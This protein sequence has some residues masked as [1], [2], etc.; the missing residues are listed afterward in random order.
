M[1]LLHLAR[2]LLSSL[3]WCPISDSTIQHRDK[4]KW[5]TESTQTCWN[6]AKSH[7]RLRIG[8]PAWCGL[9]S[10]MRTIQSVYGGNMCVWLLYREAFEH[11]CTA[12]G[13]HIHPRNAQTRWL[14]W[15]LEAWWDSW[16]G[17]DP[18][19]E[20]Y[21]CASVW[22]CVSSSKVSFEVYIY[23]SPCSVYFIWITVLSVPESL[24]CIHLCCSP[25]PFHQSSLLGP[26]HHGNLVRGLWLES[27]EHLRQ[28][29][30][31]K[32]SS[33]I[34]MPPKF[35]VCDILLLR[36]RDRV[37]FLVWN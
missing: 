12:G 27:S 10:V 2:D 25:I 11:V 7:R 31:S 18:Q 23:L 17:L 29:T 20:E 36:I 35:V 8:P 37:C 30:R 22:V 13:S 6:S 1:L 34:M 5:V 21:G 3:F 28:L 9:V 32:R 24:S 4:N 16:H 15:H 33:A 26:H 19:C 14:P